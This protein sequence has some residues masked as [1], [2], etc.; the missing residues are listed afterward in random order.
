MAVETTGIGWLNQLELERSLERSRRTGIS[1]LL[2]VMPRY[3]KYES[4]ISRSLENW[5]G[6]SFD[7]RRESGVNNRPIWESNAIFRF[8]L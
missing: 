4:E 7:Y 3:R 5:K 8:R 2:D 6:A 1:V